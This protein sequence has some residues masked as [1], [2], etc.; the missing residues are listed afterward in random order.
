[1]AQLNLYI[2]DLTLKKIQEAAKREH[3]SISSWVKKCLLITFRKNWPENYFDLFGAL[4]KDDLTRP[5]QSDFSKD[6]R[7]EA[8]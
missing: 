4:T 2:D 1:M 6:V 7:R 8:L 3:K 5:A